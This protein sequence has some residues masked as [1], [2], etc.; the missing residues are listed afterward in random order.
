[1]TQRQIFLSLKYKVK[2]KINGFTL[3]ELLIVVLIIG[4]LAAVAL[5]QYQR[6]VAKARLTEGLTVGKSIVNAENVYKMANGTYTAD[7]DAL[8]VNLPE[9]GDKQ[10]GPNWV[11]INYPAKGIRYV[12]Q[13]EGGWRLD[14]YTKDVVVQRVFDWPDDQCVVRTE[15]GRY[16]C[17]SLGANL[18]D[19]ATSGS[20]PKM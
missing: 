15:I 18:S 19:T 11:Q 2:G 7:L 14:F 3:I 13:Q 9:G 5:P 16:L 4:I 8:D 17:R 1:M 20:I 6:A 12:L 10:S